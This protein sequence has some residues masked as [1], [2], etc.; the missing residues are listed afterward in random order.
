MG[1]PSRY[2][3]DYRI[4]KRARWWRKLAEFGKS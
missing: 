4:E 3:L 1:G 2:S